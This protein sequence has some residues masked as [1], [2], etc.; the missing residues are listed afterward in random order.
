M[1]YYALLV[2]RIMPARMKAIP[3]MRWDERNSEKMM[4]PARPTNTNVAPAIIG[5]ATIMQFTAKTLT[6]KRKAN[7]YKHIAT[8]NSTL[9]QA[10]QP[11]ADTILWPANLVA[12]WAPT[13][14]RTAAM[15]SQK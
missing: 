8:N 6:V 5:P 13:L 15:A 1:A 3:T 9:N 4:T 10:S 12:T 11:E 2:T 7:V 14:H